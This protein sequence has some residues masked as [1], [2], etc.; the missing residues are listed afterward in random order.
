MMKMPKSKTPKRRMWIGGVAIVFA[1]LLMISYLPTWAA[2]EPSPHNQTVPVPTPKPDATKVPTATPSRDDDDK[3]NSGDDAEDPTPT[4]IDTPE[5]II[6]IGGGESLAAPIVGDLLTGQVVVVR[7][8]V[9]SGPATKYDIIGTL[10]NGDTVQLLGRN[11]AGTWWALCCVGENSR[12]GWVNAQFIKPGGSRTDANNALP[13]LQ[14]LN[15]LA[16]VSVPGTAAVDA[17]PLD[18]NDAAD[19]TELELIASQNPPFAAQGDS[20][21]LRFTVTNNGEL[22]ATNVSLRDQLP[23]G[24]TYISADVDAGGTAAQTGT[25]DA[26]IVR[27]VWPQLAAGESA[28]AVISVKIDGSLPFGSVIDNLAAV[29][30]DNAS[31]VTNGISIGMAP[32]TLPDF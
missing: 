18:G 13:I 8:N 5:P 31:S 7:L 29:N 1:A 14:D 24:L 6:P 15:N 26:R 25:G 4:P 2:P 3:G 17:A 12:P 20:I 21:E 16:A 30:A 27:F 10:S 9:R 11:E 32:I 19:A 23:E 22:D 28:T